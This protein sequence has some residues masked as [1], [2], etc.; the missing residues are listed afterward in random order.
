MKTT[1]PNTVSRLNTVYFVL[2]GVIGGLYLAVAKGIQ[3]LAL[4]QGGYLLYGIR[5]YDPTFIPQDWLTWQV[6]HFEFAFAYLLYCLQWIGS[7]A[8]TTVIVQFFTMIALAFG[9][10]MMARQFCKHYKAVFIMLIVWLVFVGHSYEIGLG[11]Q[12]FLMNY[13]VPSEISSALL[14]LGLAFLFKRHYFISGLLLGLMGLFHTAYITSYALIILCTVLATGIWRNL[15]SLFSFALPVGLLWGIPV[16]VVGYYSVS[17]SAD[18]AGLGSYIM[19]NFRNP[20]DFII[21]NWPLKGTINWFMWCGIG[22]LGMFLTLGEKTFRELRVTFLAVLGTIAIGVAQMV[23]VKNLS[24]TSLMLWRAAPLASILGL[25]VALDRCLHVVIKPE[26][27]QKKDKIFIFGVCI[28]G[29]V[30]VSNGWGPFFDKTLFL[31]IAAIPFA[32]LI[33]WIVYRLKKD[34]SFRSKTIYVSLSIFMAV[35]MVKMSHT[36]LL[37]CTHNHFSHPAP[38]SV[39]DLEEWIRENTPDDSIFVIHP[40][41]NESQIRIR[42][43]RAVVVGIKGLPHI[44]S[45]IEEWYKRVCDVCGFSDPYPDAATISA[46]TMI[47]GYRHLDTNRAKLLR[48]RHG[49]D[50]VIISAKGHV[51]DVAGLLD[52]YHNEAYRVLEIPSVERR[53]Y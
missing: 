24:I 35:I 12:V 17:Q 27:I 51:G 19:V 49:A 30:L 14:I 45:Y 5:L 34:V 31:W 16:L 22:A 15:K 26:D 53:A 37:H 33:G 4:G 39:A 9:L 48:Q 2:L 44:P 46:E 10:L 6:P 41:M 23:F 52:R 13:F 32:A 7:L 18:S 50:Y 21:S 1:Y 40:Q 36:G 8:T 38:D 25:L 43:R 20:G 3:F 47:D 29:A 11:W 28:A 42:T